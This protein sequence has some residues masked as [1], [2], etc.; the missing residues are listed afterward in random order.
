MDRIN[1]TILTLLLALP[2]ASAAQLK[3]AEAC[4]NKLAGVTTTFA[5]TVSFG[6]VTPT[7]T[8]LN[9]IYSELSTMSGST[10]STHHVSGLEYYAEEMLAK[11]NEKMAQ[12]P[13]VRNSIASAV[14][15]IRANANNQVANRYWVDYTTA[16]GIANYMEKAGTRDL[17][18]DLQNRL[19]TKNLNLL[20][21]VRLS[22]EWAFWMDA[23]LSE[24]GQ[25][26]PIVDRLK[27]FEFLS[28]TNEFL[29]DMNS[30]F[31]RGLMIPT[32]DPLG[33]AD[34]VAISPRPIFPLGLISGLAS[35]DGAKMGPVKF[36]AHDT[37]HARVAA[38]NN[39]ENPWRTIFSGD[40]PT[41][42]KAIADRQ[43]LLD[44][45]FLL[46]SQELSPRLQK[47]LIVVWFAA[48]HETG[49]PAAITSLHFGESKMVIAF[50]AAD[51]DPDYGI[52][53]NQDLKTAETW[54]TAALNPGIGSTFVRLKIRWHRDD[55]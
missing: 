22:I 29:R 40:I 26:L 8:R 17:A 30:I 38:S 28:R 1:R 14:Q 44:K 35:A 20:D 9:A 16:I 48:S 11:L 52:L 31:P 2:V 13:G 3:P 21:F 32:T 4:A 7:V 41:M 27:D 25:L 42:T 47:S 39:S 50:A 10:A 12:H 6:N 45:T 43:T 18:A 54:L 19:K 55:N 51:Q 36:F 34:F 5:L 46:A 23:C 24:D 37:G 15:T 49:R 53:T 33:F